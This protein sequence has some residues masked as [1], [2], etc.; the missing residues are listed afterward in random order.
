MRFNPA[1]KIGVFSCANG[2]GVI[3]NF[4]THDVVAYSIF[5]LILGT[6]QSISQILSNKVNIGK[7]YIEHQLI[8]SHKTNRAS[9]AL[10]HSRIMKRVVLEDVLGIYGHPHDGDVRISYQ[11]GSGNTTLQIYFSEWTYGRLIPVNGTNTTFSVEW[12]TNV[13]HHFYTYPWAVPDFWVDFGVADTVLLRAGEFDLFEEYEFVK[14]ATLD[15]FP[16][17]PWTPTSCGPE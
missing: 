14:N 1:T 13:M 8:R 9:T 10:H 11:P 12:E 5:Q 15:T 17:I 16:P 7:P 3:A 6:N 2:P 4:P